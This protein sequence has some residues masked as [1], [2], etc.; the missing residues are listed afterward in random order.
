MLLPSPNFRQANFMHQRTKKRTNYGPW[1][2]WFGR[3]MIGL[4]GWKLIGEKPPV[5]KMVIVAAPHASNWDLFYTLLAAMGFGIPAVFTMKDFWFFWPLGPLMYWLGGIPIDRSKRTNTVDQI[6]TAFDE[7]EK[8]FLVIP[9]EGTRKA[10]KYW[11]LGFYWI[12]VGAKVPL[13]FAYIDYKNRRVGLGDLIY[14]TGDVAA[15]FVKIRA[16]YSANV[17]YAPDFDPT[18]VAAPAKG[19]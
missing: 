4:C 8:M 17:D 7:S 16:F 15:D 18:K 13:L 11:K 12:A 9:P 14:P 10:V 1:A 2:R 3:T 6:V 19:E 5:D